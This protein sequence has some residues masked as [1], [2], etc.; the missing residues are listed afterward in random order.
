MIT[1]SA[2]IPATSDRFPP[3]VMIMAGERGSA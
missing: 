1:G 2:R 3:E